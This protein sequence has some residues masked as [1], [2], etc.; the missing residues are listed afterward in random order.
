MHGKALALPWSLF[1]LTTGSVSA[2]LS[3]LD[4]KGI[5][6]LVSDPGGSPVAAYTTLQTQLE[7][8]RFLGNYGPVLE[9]HGCMEGA[10]K[11]HLQLVARNDCPQDALS[12]WL[13]RLFP[14][15]DGSSFTINS[16][17]SDPISHL[18]PRVIGQVLQRIH[19]VGDFDW[20]VESRMR[21]LEDHL[22]EI[23]FHGL[24]PVGYRSKRSDQLQKELRA[25][26]KKGKKADPSRLG[27]IQ[28]QILVLGEAPSGFSGSGAGAGRASDYHSGKERDYRAIA[29]VLVA[30]LQES[31]ITVL[32]ATESVY[33]KYLPEQALL[34]FFIKKA[35]EKADL[36]E[37]FQGMP[38][39]VKDPDFLA[40]SAKQE[41]FI[42]QKW[43]HSDYDPEG[44]LHDPE[45]AISAFSHDPEYLVFS[46][47]EERLNRSLP[48]RV[49]MGMSKHSSLGVEAYPDCGETTLR[50]FFNYI[51]Y[52][53]VQQRFDF[54]L[55][56][57]FKDADPT[58][59]F[60]PELV[61]FYEEY[62][63]PASSGHQGVR[64]RWSEK[65]VSSR[66]GVKYMKP[67]SGSLLRKPQC[68]MDAGIDNLLAL[69]DQLIFHHPDG[70]EGPLV[71][72]TPRSERLDLLCR[73]LSREG[74][75]LTWKVNGAKTEASSRLEVDSKDLGLKLLF[76]FNGKPKFIWHLS[77]GHFQIE[78]ISEASGIWREQLVGVLLKGADTPPSVSPSWFVTQRGLDALSTRY[79][80]SPHL[81]S[82]ILYSIPLQSAVGMSAGFR[83]IVTVGQRWAIPMKSLA[84]RLK[85]GVEAFHDL[86]F[87]GRIH[88]A[89][90]EGG[91]P[92]DDGMVS[93]VGHPEVQYERVSREVI[94]KN[95]GPIAAKKMGRTWRRRGGFLAIGEPLVDSTGKEV[96]AHFESALR[97]CL[98]LNPLSQREGV[99]RQLRER[100][101][102]LD[103]YRKFSYS[104]RK[105]MEAVLRGIH[106]R[107]PISGCYLMSREEWKVLE[108]DFDLGGGEGERQYLPQIFPHLGN[109]WF[110]SSS[111]F[112]R[113]SSHAFSFSG[114]TGEVM[115]QARHHNG[116]VRCACA[117]RSWE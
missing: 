22:S 35:N 102:K 84:D 44:L 100:E 55:F 107:M 51:L 62:S 18:T 65:V 69:I 66:L 86:H 5:E 2:D 46:M 97:A 57:Q 6:A 47:M 34:A 24:N 31:R 29:Q 54:R 114:L 11:I 9:S 10:S 96:T 26:Q 15:A 94:A 59:F 48:P 40:N 16:L 87:L 21:E 73:A 99:E 67:L 70:S 43:K 101:S 91:Y 61:Q 76:S 38:N 112:P 25:E 92:Y 14:S 19:E 30:A 8:R 117:S 113:D 52:D 27:E 49:G 105:E 58:L 42:A 103:T 56:H 88:Q 63:H 36:V 80:A 109:R 79:I 23:F 13:Q 111:E 71:K 74:K 41:F 50:N 77:P 82:S 110:W 75:S 93:L 108:D 89:L 53:F 20:L 83:Q 64:D 81:F 12:E 85:A 60:H 39:L 95:F 68:E 115:D 72:A 90:A 4:L 106:R 7:N 32:P 104:S 116:A 17:P 78:P 98:S 1:F 37:L 33:P 45:K 28:R 3:F